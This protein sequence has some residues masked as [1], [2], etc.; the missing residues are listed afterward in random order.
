MTDVHYMGGSISISR[1][2]LTWY[3]EVVLDKTS[4]KKLVENLVSVEK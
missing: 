1:A 2:L 3:F 4:T